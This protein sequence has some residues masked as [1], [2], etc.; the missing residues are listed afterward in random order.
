ML[1][2]SCLALVGRIIKISL[3]SMGIL[4][5]SASAACATVLT[6]LK[7]SCA[8]F[9]VFSSDILEYVISDMED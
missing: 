4:I 3:L 1:V 5:M 9:N 2:A 7:S 8:V 6:S